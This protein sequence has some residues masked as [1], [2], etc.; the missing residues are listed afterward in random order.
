MMTCTRRGS[1]LN[2]YLL[3]S[4]RT[5]QVQAS[6]EVKGA[7]FPRK[8]FGFYFPKVPFPG[9]LSHSDRILARFYTC[10]LS[11]LRRDSHACRLKT[12]ISRRLTLA[13]QFLTPDWKMWV[14][15]VLL[16]TISK[17][18]VNSDPC[19]ERKPCVKWSLKW[20]ALGGSSRLYA[21]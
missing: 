8:C 18:Y 11:R 5:Q 9:F 12:L 7:C 1:R 15:A 20:K 16:D 19:K 13:G 3:N 2:T 10:Q 4:K 17:K 14:V 21:S 6:R